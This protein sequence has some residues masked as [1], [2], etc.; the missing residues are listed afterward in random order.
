MGAQKR[1]DG[2]TDDVSARLPRVPASRHSYPPRQSSLLP[3]LLAQNRR[4]VERGAHTRSRQSSS[5]EHSSVGP[6]GQL[7]AAQPG[8]SG[9]AGGQSSQHGLHGDVRNSAGK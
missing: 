8:A 9:D 2:F 3:Q 5:A 6:L 7:S 4:S 1:T